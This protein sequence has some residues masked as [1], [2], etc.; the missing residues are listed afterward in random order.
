MN[1]DKKNSA[2]AIKENVE[3][4]IRTNELI[5]MKKVAQDSFATE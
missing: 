5:E 3:L 2:E 1:T 4:I